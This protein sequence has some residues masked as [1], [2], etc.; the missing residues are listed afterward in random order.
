MDISRYWPYAIEQEASLEHLIE[1]FNAWSSSIKDVISYFHAHQQLDQSVVFEHS[2]L[3][4]NL[5]SRQ[6]T[7]GTFQLT[8]V[9]AISKHSSPGKI[10][11]CKPK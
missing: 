4:K 1:R 7:L 5:E 9:S 8:K 11:L 10:L 2:K 3:L 6:N